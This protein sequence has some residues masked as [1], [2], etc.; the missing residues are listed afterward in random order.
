MSDGYGEIDVARVGP[1]HVRL[2]QSGDGR[3]DEIFV[4][5]NEI[6]DL[7]NAL[8]VAEPGTSATEG[9]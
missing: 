8:R 4:P 3:T 2:E 5:I 6:D 7:V 1:D 9:K